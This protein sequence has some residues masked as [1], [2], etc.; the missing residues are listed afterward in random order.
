MLRY[1][2]VDSK[3]L[4]RQE[5]LYQCQLQALK[6]SGD[7]KM[8]DAIVG[9]TPWKYPHVYLV[10]GIDKNYFDYCSFIDSCNIDFFLLSLAC[11]LLLASI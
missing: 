6:V 3:K 10:F 9:E 2:S 4:P 7:L 1:F 11:I 8:V 5:V